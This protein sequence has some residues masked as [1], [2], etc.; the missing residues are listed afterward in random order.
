MSDLEFD[1]LNYPYASRRTTTAANNGMVA[2]AQP[3]ASQAGL[4][5]LKKGGNAVDA[6]IATAA[7]LTVVEPTSN[8]IGG[9]A[10]A[11]VWMKDDLHGLNASGPAPKSLSIEEVKAR[12]HET[13][14]KY[15][16]L[17]VTVPG[18]PAAWG[19]LS[20]KFGKLTL[21]DVL[22]PA[23][24]YAKE[25]YPV[26]PVVAYYWGAAYNKYKEVL[27]DDEFK[28]WFETFAPK[29]RAPKPGEVWSS[30]DHA[31]TLEIIAESNGES[32]YQGE[33]ADKIVSFANAHDGFMTKEDLES[34]EPEWVDPISINYQGYDVWELPPNGQGM[35]A[36]N[37]LNIL[38]QLEVDEQMSVDS[39]HK[40]IEALKL[41][42][43]DGQEYITDPN[44]MKD[45]LPDFLSKEYGK[46]R[47]ALITDEAMTP[48]PGQ[49]PSGGTVYLATADSEGNMVSYIQSNYRGF[50]SGLVVPGTG[51]A[52]QNRGEAFSL[53]ANAANALEG[54][55]RTFHTIIPGFLTKD[56]APISPFG[57]M[58]GPMQPQGHLQVVKNMIDYNLNPQAALDAPRWQ[59]VEDKKVLVE[60][61]FPKHLARSLSRRGHE[62]K[63][64]INSGSFGRGQIIWWDKATNTYFGG[65]D[66]RADGS[67]SAY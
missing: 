23:I 35:I 31:K 30:N 61:D 53:D 20:E 9:D 48:K 18:V 60:M 62:I 3:L 45:N 26:S 40:E 7:A 57:V 11:L 12:G 21:G 64:E 52:L 65:T 67:I 8:G 27:A 14:P 29:G 2:T 54:G 59:W 33:L 58:G 36:L 16:W 22:Q 38:N 32:F 6:A 24:T 56:Q 5:I 42:F 17:P 49:L 15:G 1:L 28:T 51:I 66:G 37:A 13:M 55:K 63:V 39:Y 34:F 44:F 25:G 50:G 4:D 10:F 43:S 47:S 46:R 41:A 19:A